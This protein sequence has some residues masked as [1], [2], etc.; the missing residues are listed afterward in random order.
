MSEELKPCPFCGSEKHMAFPPTCDRNTPY[1][2]N[3]RAFPIIRCGGCFTEVPG[4]DWD[5]SCKTAGER[6]ND[7]IENAEVVRLRAALDSIRLYANDTLSGRVDGPDDRQWQREAVIECR[8]RA[9]M[10]LNPEIS[11]GI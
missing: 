8:N 11:Y 5:A 9:R 10:A 7:R 6:W 1:N 2:P 3:D 4:K